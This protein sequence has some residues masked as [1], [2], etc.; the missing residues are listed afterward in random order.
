MRT[1]PVTKD[2]STVALGLAQIRVGVSAANVSNPNICFTSADSMGAMADTKMTSN[3]EYWKLTSGFPALEDLSIPLSESCSFECVFKEITPR[4]MALARGIDPFSVG[5]CFSATAV[6]AVLSA[7]GKYSGPFS[8]QPV[9]LNSVMRTASVRKAF[10][11]I[12]LPVSSN[13]FLSSQEKTQKQE[14]AAF[15]Q[16]ELFSVILPPSRK[17]GI[18]P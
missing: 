8:P 13:L 16:R 17:T 14:F 2:V 12:K 3:V 10:F 6:G 18:K 9:R 15:L 4:N 11:I 1:G 5:T 7:G